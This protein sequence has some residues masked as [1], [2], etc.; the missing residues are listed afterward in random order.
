MD[1]P[2]SELKQI[3]EL[4]EQARNG[5]TSG[6]LQEAL[7]AVDE[8]LAV[9]AQNT[10]SLD[11]KADI[12]E[13]MGQDGEAESLRQRVKQLKREAWQRKVEAEARGKH[14]VMGEAIRH[15]KL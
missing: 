11:L 1:A 10:R 9:E 15:E 8:A 13:K 3:K 4:Q 12:L 6:S 5:L 2:I 7:T 14:E